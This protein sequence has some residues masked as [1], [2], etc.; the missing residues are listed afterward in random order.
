M[1]SFMHWRFGG[2][3]NSQ[4]KQIIL[5]LTANLK[6]AS[7]SGKVAH[8]SEIFRTLSLLISVFQSF[9]SQKL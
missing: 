4:L 2:S 5:N 7:I 1:I 3:N 9:L 8:I 6:K